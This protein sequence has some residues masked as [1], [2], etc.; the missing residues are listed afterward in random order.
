MA[1]SI[2]VDD[3][4][5]PDRPT[6][7]RYITGTRRTH[8]AVV[9]QQCDVEHVRDQIRKALVHLGRRLG[10]APAE[11][12]FTDLY[13]RR[14]VWRGLPPGKNLDLLEVFARLYR[15]FRWKVYVQTVDN[16]TIRDW[17][18]LLRF[19]GIDGLNPKES[20]ADLSL[21]LLCL[22]IRIAYTATR[23]P[24]R[25]YVDQGKPGRNA[26]FGDQ[27][28]RAWGDSYS[29]QF[30]SSTAEPLLQVA[31][32]VAFCINR[33]TYLGTKAQR[34][35][36]DTDFLRMVEFMQIN[37]DR[38]VRWKT[39]ADFTVADFDEAFRNDRSEKGLQDQEE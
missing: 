1:L 36:V 21:L 24:I 37:C 7:S 3:T 35:N 5:G 30:E 26:P 25:L 6:G 28:F 39:K 13:N 27:L 33:A 17:P 12:H 10:S 16:Y 31:D 20:R 9:F 29:G 15:H 38:L 11:F 23:P 8:V 2:A 14:G 4:Y 22:Q 19:G 18:Q 32:F 34:S